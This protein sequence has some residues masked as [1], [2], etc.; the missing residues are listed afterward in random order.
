[1]GV[2]LSATLAHAAAYVT[3]M[4]ADGTTPDMRGVWQVHDTAYLNIEGH[5]AVGGHAAARSIVDTADHK[6]PYRPEALAARDHNARQRLTADPAVKCFEAGVPRAT[7]APAPFLIAQSV[8]P[9]GALA[10]AYQDNHA[11]RIVYP[12]TM[13]HIS[14]IDWW[15]GDTR[16]HWEGATLVVDGRS[17]NHLAWLDAAG[18]HHSDDMHV[19]ERYT[20]TGPDTISYAAW[21]DDPKIYTAPW[22]LRDTLY[23]DARP[24]ARIV[25]D[26]CLDDHDGVRHHLAPGDPRALQRNSYTRW[27]I[28]QK[29][30][31]L[32]G[33]ADTGTPAGQGGAVPNGNAPRRAAASSIPRLADGHPDFN[34]IWRTVPDFIPPAPRKGV[35]P[36]V[37]LLGM[38]RP[39]DDASRDFRFA[40]VTRLPY[41]AAGQQ[42]QM[43]R[44]RH[45]FLDG[46]PRCHIAGVPRALVM[47][48]YPEQIVQDERRIT[49][50]F[51]NVHEVRTIPL[52]G[53]A[54]PKG[55]AA[56]D[57]DSR[58]HWEGDTLVVDVR[59]LNGRTWLNMTGNFVD[60]NE[61]AVERYTFVD[62]DTVDYAVTV[63]DP[64]VFTAPFTLR[65]PMLRQAANEQIL[66]FACLEGEADRQHY[67][68]QFGG[69]KVAVT[70][71]G[72]DTRA[73]FKAHSGAKPQADAGADTGAQERTGCLRGVLAA[74]DVRFRLQVG[75]SWTA[76]VPVAVDRTLAR[77]LVETIDREVSLHGRVVDAMF[78]AQA[79]EVLAE[80]C[81]AGYAPPVR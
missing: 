50:L 23:R 38:P 22:T 58:G 19:I 79:V 59:D 75:A 1:M 12:S 31:L 20:R 13:P 25:E 21:I 65:L 15:M 2:L 54:H 11:F 78:H 16:G 29:L 46:E 76:T 41:T 8:G 80:G 18:N 72:A 63:S 32:S 35:D 33:G 56:W 39:G 45:Q 49:Q 4:L 71:D 10:F 34:G 55:Y 30:G 60:E 42:E 43:W 52:D 53:S 36:A 64:G 81:N 28:A 67:T 51:E 66:E 3:P 5:P 24:G 61:H 73:D 70:A 27:S 57:G 26:E 68:E 14:G 9:H 77:M 62:A 47:P 69:T 44:S 74:G 7:Y 40:G 17:F 37:A 6:I 48:P